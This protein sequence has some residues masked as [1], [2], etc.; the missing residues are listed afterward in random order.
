M[1]TRHWFEISKYISQTYAVDG[2]DGIRQSMT[3]I[4]SYPSDI[5][6]QKETEFQI[7]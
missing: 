7:I 3:M 4:R 5:Q 1:T 6:K 2:L